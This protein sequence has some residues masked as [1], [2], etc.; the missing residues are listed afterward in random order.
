M[1][2]RRILMRQWNLKLTPAPPGIIA[3]DSS[4][5]QQASM[6]GLTDGASRI[7]VYVKA[8]EGER[9]DH[10]SFLELAG[11]D[12]PLL[13]EQFADLRYVAGESL[14]TPEI[15]YA[16][17]DSGIQVITRVPDRLS[18][19]GDLIRETADEELEPIPGEC[20]GE[21]GDQEEQDLA[22]GAALPLLAV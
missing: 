5:Q 16:A 12:W 19:A 9:P 2:C 15:L 18:I 20:S 10:Q 11:R 17:V 14:C 13:R 8:L 3:A 4:G 22:G 7:P 1:I 6:L 21:D